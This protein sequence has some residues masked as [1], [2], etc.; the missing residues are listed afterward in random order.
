MYF[1]L[2]LLFYFF[3]TFSLFLLFTFHLSPFTFYSLRSQEETTKSKSGSVATREKD[4]KQ[5]SKS[6]VG[7][8][9]PTD[10]EI[11]VRVRVVRGVSCVRSCGR[12]ISLQRVFRIRVFLLLLLCCSPPALRCS[13]GAPTVSRSCV[14]M[15]PSLSSCF[16]M[17]LPVFMFFC[18]FIFVSFFSMPYGFES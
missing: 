7:R 15:F 6:E 8:M 4:E 9:L 18:F 2:F 14:F 16:C 11:E 3:F 17:M 10:W 12:D 5:T 1:L 13:A